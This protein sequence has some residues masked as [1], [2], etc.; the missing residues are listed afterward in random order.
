MKKIMIMLTLLIGLLLAPLAGRVEAATVPTFAIQGVSANDKVTIQTYNFPA[1][2]EFVARMGILGTKGVGGIQVGKVASGAGGSLKFTF[3]IPA[4]L[5]DKDAIAIRLDSTTGGYYAYNWFYNDTFGSHTGGVP[6]DGVSPSPMIMVASVKADE[7][8]MIKATDLPANETFVVRM[9]LFGTNGVG[10]VQVA[11]INSGADG[12]FVQAFSIP[13]TLKKTTKLDIRF[14]SQNSTL[15]LFT[16]FTNVTGGSGG[17]G[18]ADSGYVGIPTIS[19]TSVVT[20]KTVTI[21]THNFPANKE[22]QVLMGKMWTRGVGGT[23]VKTISSGS[24]G[25]F[26]ATFDIP[27]AL[28]GDNRIA[29]RLQT[30]NNYFYA[31]N[32]FYNNTTGSGDPGV[33]LPGYTGIPTFSITGVVADQKVTITTNNLPPNTDFVVKM[34]KMWTKAIGGITVTTF[35]SGTGGVVTKTFDVPAALKGEGRIAIRMDATVGGFYAYNW[36]YNNTYP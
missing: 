30:A 35:N 4:A 33:V 19:I 10:G 13:D 8:V 14:E 32:W 24:G 6:A 23:L 27:A 15:V 5:Y 21:Q 16:T 7:T 20:D 34:G 9:N 36:F 12:N 31:Y 25:S 29:I 18:G 26:A 22:F 3:S 11:T 28:K 17:S 1:G 2:K